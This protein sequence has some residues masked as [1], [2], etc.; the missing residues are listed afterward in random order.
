MMVES[1]SDDLIT[2]NTVHLTGDD[3]FYILSRLAGL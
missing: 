2:T 1:D 3:G